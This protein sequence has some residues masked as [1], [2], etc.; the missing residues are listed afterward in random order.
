MHVAFTTVSW[1]CLLHARHQDIDRAS[2]VITLIL[3]IA[4][5]LQTGP[6]HGRDAVTANLESFAAAAQGKA[7]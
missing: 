5:A 4:N 7:P 3:D 6:A 1:S 2:D